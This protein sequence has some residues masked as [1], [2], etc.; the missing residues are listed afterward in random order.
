MLDGFRESE[1][2]WK[3]LLQRRQATRPGR[4]IRRSP[5]AD[6]ALGFWA[7]DA[8]GMARRQ[9][10]QRCWVHKTANV[11][12]SL[13]NKAKARLH[14]IWQA[15]TRASAER[16]FDS[17]VEDFAM[18]YPKA[19]ECLTKDRDVLLTFYDFPAEHWKHLRTTNPIESNVRHGA[20]SSRPN[21]GQ[22]QPCGVPGDGF[23]TRAVSRETLAEIERSSTSSPTSSAASGSST[24]SNTKPPP[25]HAA[26]HK[27]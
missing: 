13:Q 4:S 11:P 10:E 20:T 2:S 1:Q 27:I 26:I 7:A 8:Q 14:D 12:K 17:F 15:E 3:E 9:R 22:R 16:A 24:A 19:V 5:I 21:E 23:Q 18:K 25:K 6:G